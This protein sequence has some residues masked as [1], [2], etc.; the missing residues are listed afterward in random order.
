MPLLPLLRLVLTPMLLAIVL[1]AAVAW[2]PAA[3]AQGPA[4]AL[5]RPR[6]ALVVA[7]GT[8]GGREVLESARPDARAVADA[9]NAAGFEVLLREDPDTPT[10]RAALAEFKGRLKSEAKPDA[11]GLIYYTGPA[12]QVDG[13]NLLLPSDVAPADTM[14]GPAVAALLRAVGLPLQEAANALQGAADAPRA[15][16]VDAAYRHPVLQRLQ[17]PGLAPLR[18]PPGTMGLLGHAPGALQEVMASAPPTR[19]AKVMVEAITTPRISVPEALRA[20]RLAVQDGSGGRTLP[21][22]G[23]ETFG[24]EFLADAVRLE[25]PLPAAQTAT[26]PPAQTAT[27]PPAPGAAAPAASA[28]AAVALAASSA[29]SAPARATDGR[30][31]PA[32]GQGER[33]AQRGRAN[34]WGLAEGDTLSYQVTDTRKDELLQSYTVAI[35]AVAAD[36]SLRANGGAWLLDPQGRV[37]QQ[38]TEGGAQTRFEPLQGTWWQQPRSGESREVAFVED[39]VA[40]DRSRSRTE[41]RGTAQV[42]TPRLVETAAGEFEALPI[43]TSGRFTRRPEGAPAQEGLFV[44]TVWFAPRLALPVVVEIEDSDSTG[45]ALR[46]E[47]IELI[48][49]QTARN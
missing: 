37:L 13:R 17:P 28:P 16:V 25:Q 41:W 21:W 2:T 49:A 36:G 44:H 23:G 19:F 33:P 15:L 24:R 14:A 35:D 27:P 5:P 12:A 46:R 32:P 7:V 9:L 47:R 8:A 43:R 39:H 38:R 42:G 4:A 40:A 31:T 3:A 20:V 6:V 1:A 30:T 26:P 18:L 45:R 10:L 29:A 11:V 48:L 22:V 34:S